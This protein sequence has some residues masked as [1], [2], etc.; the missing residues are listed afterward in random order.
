MTDA[1]TP[2]ATAP[3]T[4]PFYH[5]TKAELAP[6]D[7][8]GPGYASNYGKRAKANYVYLTGTL[9]AAIWGRSWPWARVGEGSIS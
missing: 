6:G 9:D 8:I 5:G 4:G 1:N 7:L 3:G 2:D